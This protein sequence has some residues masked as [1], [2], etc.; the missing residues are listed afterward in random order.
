MKYIVVLGDGMADYPVKELGGKTPLQAAKKENMDEMARHGEV[1]LV[2]TTPEGM[3]PGSD[4]TNLGIMGYDPRRYYTGRSPLEAISIG[5]SLTDDDVTF[6][7]NLV[8]LS[9]DEP[10]EQ[11]TMIDYSADEITTPEAAELVKYLQKSLHPETMNMKM[12]P[13]IYYRHCLVWNHGMTGLTLTPPHDISGK[14]ITYYLPEGKGS[15]V[16]YELQKKSYELLKDHPVNMAR[17]KRGLRQA[18]SVWF[19]GEGKKPQLSSLYERFGKKAVVISAVDLIKGIGISAGMKS[20]DVEG[21]TGNFDTNYEGK[22][23]AALRA[24]KEGYDYAYI[25]LE[26]PDECG[27]RHEIENKVKAIEWIDSRLI[28]VLRKGLGKMGEAHSIL[29]LPD[30]PTPID[31][32]THARDAVPY[33]LYCSEKDIHN[34]AACYS[35]A[36]AA[37]TGMFIPRADVMLEKLFAL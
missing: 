26:G 33:V 13:G 19:W 20:I 5:V 12:Y 9:E 3:P 11:K 36:E 10:Y 2:Q 7:M 21:A 25:H 37:K 17:K 28:G 34:G 32:R 15:E 14:K 31:L 4:T 24:L 22:A 27:H 35:E 1:G 30:H 16:F 29:V 8:T 6:R 18:N 23:N